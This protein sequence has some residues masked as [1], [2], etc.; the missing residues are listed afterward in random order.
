M[1]STRCTCSRNLDEFIF[2]FKRRNARERGLL[3]FRLLER[4]VEVGPITYRDL[5]AQPAPTG[6]KGKMPGQRGLPG[7]LAVPPLDRPWR[8]AL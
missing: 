2:R 6:R 5:V 8:S 4:T 3:F 7:T 1:P